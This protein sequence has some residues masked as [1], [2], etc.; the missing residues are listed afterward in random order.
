MLSSAAPRGGQ[1]VALAIADPSG[2]AAVSVPSLVSVAWGNTSVAFTASAVAVSTVHAVTLKATAN[3]VTKTTSILVNPA[4]SSTSTWSVTGTVGPS[5][6]GA[7]VAVNLTGT[8][9]A[10]ATTNS[11]G[12]FSFTGLPKGT[13]TLTASKTGLI[14]APPTEQITVNSANVSGL[15]FTARSS[16]AIGVDVK[17][18]S[19]QDTSSSTVTSPG[20]KT[21]YQNE[22]LLAFVSADAVTSP[23]TTVKSVTG[24]GLTW[25]LVSRANGRRGTSEI[26]RA[27]APNV[28][29][30]GSV[31]ATL[32]QSVTSSIVVMTFTGVNASGTSG[33]GAIGASAI[34]SG[35]GGAP[36]ASLVTTKTNSM[37]VGAGNESN[38]A[39]VLTPASGQSLV[40]QHISSSDDTYWVQ[41]LNA[42]V[43]ASGTKVTISDTGSTTDRY[44]LAVCEVLAGS[45][46]ATAP[47]PPPPP[48]VPQLTIST[49]SLA[50][51]SVAVNKTSTLPLTL[52][53]SGTGA[54]TIN[55]AALTGSG[56]QITGVTTPLTLN[57]NQA[58]TLEISFTPTTTTA[59]TGQ[60]SVSSTSTTGA[61]T[62]IALS[63]TGISASGAQLTI[64]QTSLSFG[65]VPLGS[66][67]TLPVTLSSDG[68]SAVT[69]S[70][71]AL[72]GTGLTMTGATFP[73]T[74]NPNLAITVDVMF[75]P[76][77]AGAV[78][79]QLNITSTSTTGAKAVVS[80][81]GTGEHEVTLSWSAPSSA[82]DPV[83]GYHIYRAA[84]GS[85]AFQLLN[86]AVETKTAYSD[87][88]VTA[89]ATYNYIVK[90]VDSSG[91]ESKASNQIA[92]TIP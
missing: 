89:G 20:F 17:Y 48:L 37:V 77:T 14:F 59:T 84:A 16:T 83:A 65:N 69:I 74:L 19:S 36:A 45:G 53:S 32:S 2:S 9:S 81:T 1:S 34:G 26:W 43:P 15:T 76:T 3:A 87:S 55:S 18:G 82:A 52:L 40:K 56:F 63:G 71:A 31:T 21:Q 6:L 88:S 47:P 50:F 68:S 85:T 38:N 7:G 44:D 29:A 46:T 90:S 24:G 54:V 12:A 42:T 11:S 66:S 33:S 4:S 41:M 51:G 35:N 91:A 58:V 30:G 5:T 13:Y 64:S 25:V 79:G 22:L 39:V 8:K 57:P 80:I 78:A 92:L 23:N 10:T 72:T 73:V 62:V 86:S 60:L 61:K 70:A 28:L 75:T 49:A 67:S 27:F